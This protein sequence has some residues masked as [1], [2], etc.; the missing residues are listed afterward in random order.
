MY[1]QYRDVLPV[2]YETV[3]KTK[4]ARDEETGLI[5]D[6]IRDSRLYDIGYFH[7][8]L[9]LNSIGRVLVAENVGFATY[10]AQNEKQALTAL[11]KVNEF[12]FEN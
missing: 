8:E 9:P 10:Y 12:Y 4:A 5:L 3:C 6:L 7:N 2:Y 11:D 1:L